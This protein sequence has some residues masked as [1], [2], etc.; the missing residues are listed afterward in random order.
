MPHVE[1][2]MNLWV[3]K[4]T[5]IWSAKR[6]W[7]N[8]RRHTRFDRSRVPNAYWLN[9]RTLNPQHMCCCV[10]GSDLPRTTRNST[11]IAILLWCMC[12]FVRTHTPCRRSPRVH[13]PIDTRTCPIESGARTPPSI[14]NAYACNACV[15]SI[16]RREG[17]GTVG[18]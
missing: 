16:A 11:C 10:Y 1:L 6:K 14:S 12:I 5:S 9:T 4:T 3:V 17:A 13:T 7:R 8:V 2:A 18:H 15:P